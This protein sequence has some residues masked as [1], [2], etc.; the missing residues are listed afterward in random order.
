VRRKRRRRPGLASPSKHRRQISHCAGHRTDD[1]DER[2][3]PARGWKVAGRRNASRGRLQSTYAA[4]VCR[5]ANRSAAVAPYAPSRHSRRDG[6]RFAAALEPP[7]VRSRSHGLLVRPKR[8]LS[9]SHAMS[10][11][12][13]LVTPSTIAPRLAQACDQ[14]RVP[15]SNKTRAQARAGFATHAC[16]FDRALDADRNA[17]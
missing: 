4:E 10:N 7:G 14:W 16:D 13:V 17:V 6:G 12:G 11:S 1:A 5:H 2:E 3:W 9:V 15:V 8:R